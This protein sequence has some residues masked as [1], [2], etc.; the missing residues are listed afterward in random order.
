MLT[1]NQTPWTREHL[2]Q[3]RRSGGRSSQ[4]SKPAGYPNRMSSGCTKN[5][6]D[7]SV[8]EKKSW[9]QWRDR[10]IKT[11]E[12]PTEDPT[13]M[14]KDRAYYFF[15]LSACTSGSRWSLEDPTLGPS[16][17]HIIIS[18]CQGVVKTSSQMPKIFEN[19]FD[20]SSSILIFADTIYM[21]FSWESIWYI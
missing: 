6:S 21:G 18:S 17:L 4:H 8:G 7:W 11:H 13:S 2:C 5:S 12:D 20:A 15:A 3:E 16:A 1:K 10:Y 19:W 9:T 14:P